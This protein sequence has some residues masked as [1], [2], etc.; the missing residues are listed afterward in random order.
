MSRILI[1]GANGQLGQCFKGLEQDF[2]DLKLH[3]CS[4]EDLDVTDTNALA[5]KIGGE[6]YDYLINCAAYTAVDAAESAVELAKQLNETAVGAIAQACHKHSVHFI[7]IST[8]FVFDGLKTSPYTSE[9]AT[10]PQSVYGATKRAGEERIIKSGVNHSIIRASWLYS[11]YANNFYK[12]VLR[13]AESK[14]QIN[15]VN[16]QIG[17]PVS[18][19][20]LAK[21]LLNLI[22]RDKLPSGILHFAHSGQCSW[23]EFAQRIVEYHKL[24]LKIESISTE[25]YGAA[26]K[27]PAYSVMQ[28]SPCFEQISWEQALK[29]V[30]LASKH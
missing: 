13:L 6:E 30:V 1:T 12:T 20:E 9:D 28:Q 16:D 15:V 11:K 22:S 4:K 25:A 29:D 23:M 14:D 27:R 19:F 17:V 18:A 5:T 10:N 3:F 2:E 21:Q 7:H 8:D 26:A 24:D